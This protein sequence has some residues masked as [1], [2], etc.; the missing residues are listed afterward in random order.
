MYLSQQSEAVR[1]SLPSQT[2][3][4]SLHS[5]ADIMDVDILDDESFGGDTSDIE[6]ADG[7]PLLVSRLKI[8]CRS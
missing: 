2:S 6:T 8:L 4:S 7:E 5:A 1:R 3:Q